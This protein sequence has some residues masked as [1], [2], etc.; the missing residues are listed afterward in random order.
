MTPIMM[1]DAL[2]E[3]IKPVVTDFVLDSNIEG[4]KKAPAVISGYLSEKKTRE[5][6]QQQAMPDFPYVIVR[7]L[8]DNDTDESNM[9]QVRIICGT[10]SKD[11]QNGWRDAM[12]VAFRIKQALLAAGKFGNA[13]HVEKP[14]KTE[15][16][17]EQ[18]F[19][20]WIALLT[21]S[22][23][24]PQTQQEIDFDKGW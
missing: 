14:I 13:F 19:P 17:E 7:Y 1:V 24:V 16:P 23:S 20:E 9:A 10:Y 2:I 4:I 3:F 21:L 22:V 5:Q 18:P 8:E 12:N 11:E 15:L 6:Q